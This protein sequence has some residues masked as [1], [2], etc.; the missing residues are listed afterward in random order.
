MN[1]GN[2][3][4]NFSYNIIKE[5]IFM[6]LLDDINN[7]LWEEKGVIYCYTNLINNK[8]ILDKPQ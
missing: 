3:F 7:P 2:I 1:N 4:S 6:N 8:N 5:M